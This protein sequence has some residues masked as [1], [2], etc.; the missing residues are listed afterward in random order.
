MEFVFAVQ[1]EAEFHRYQQFAHQY[2]D[3]L[4]DYL[5]L[6]IRKYEVTEAPP[7]HRSEQRKNRDRADSR[8]SPSRLYQ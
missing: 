5:D 3:L 4:S 8:D 1:N 7:L 2:E 6:L